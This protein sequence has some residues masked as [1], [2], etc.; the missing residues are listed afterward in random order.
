MDSFAI[1]GFT[2][3]LVGVMFGLMA[4]VRLAR[5]ENSLKDKGV[6]ESDYDS[7]KLK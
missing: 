5:L 1:M 2:F 4:L 3:G 6:L 7:Q